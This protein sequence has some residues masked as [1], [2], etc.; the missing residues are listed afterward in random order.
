MTYMLIRGREALR[1]SF[2]KR[3]V[4][5]R[6]WLRKVS[7]DDLMVTSP[8]AK[9]RLESCWIMMTIAFF[10]LL[11]SK[12]S[13]PQFWHFLVSHY[14]WPGF[15]LEFSILKA[16]LFACSSC[17]TFSIFPLSVPLAYVRQVCSFA[18]CSGHE[19]FLDI[20]EGT[21]CV[22]QYNVVT[23]NKNRPLFSTLLDFY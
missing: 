11:L 12:V 15:L 13:E 10:L 6:A 16:S 2:Q 1:W 22:F 8:L 18:D 14:F 7:L 20:R 5:Q 3:C 9:W 4:S 17:F 21:H 19:A 23:F